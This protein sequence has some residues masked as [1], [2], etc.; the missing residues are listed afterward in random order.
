MSLADMHEGVARLT[1]RLEELNA[2]N[3]RNM[4]EEHP[5]ELR[6]L[7]TSIE[8]ALA[9]TFGDNTSDFRRFSS[10]A[11]LR[12]S[13]MVFTVGSRTPLS[14]Y[15][16][17]TARK[18]EAARALLGEAIRTLEEDISEQA[19]RGNAIELPSNTI[20]SND[21]FVVH[22]HDETAKEQLARFLEKLGLKA[23]ILHEQPDQGRTI[24][25]KFEDYAE[26]VGFAVILLTPDDLG[27]GKAQPVQ[28]SRARQNVIFELGYFA[29]K[30]GRGKTCLLRKGDVEMPSD[31]YGVI[32]SDLDANGGWKMKLVQE[33][34][35]AG[36]DFDANRAW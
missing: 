29:G 33:M 21:V 9:K 7:E 6:A 35:A 2:F 11:S 13:P 17:A 34:K 15:Q 19:Q 26:Q 36:L 10:A 14:E 25:E 8:R 16:D 23:I 1:K 31:L 30:L 22:G 18:A 4:V 12:W 5:P 24:I 28:G 32:Y 3:A 20:P 27:A